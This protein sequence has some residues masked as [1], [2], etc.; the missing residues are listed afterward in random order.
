MSS[1]FLDTCTCI[2]NVKIGLI[3]SFIEMQDLYFS[4]TLLDST[5]L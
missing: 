4:I 2:S 1:N 3:Q 5:L